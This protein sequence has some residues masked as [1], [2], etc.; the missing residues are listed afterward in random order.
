MKILVVIFGALALTSVVQGRPVCEECDEIP[1]VVVGEDRQK[2]NIIDAPVVCPPGQK[3]DHKGK[4]RDVW[5]KIMPVEWFEE[6]SVAKP[7]NIIDAPV[8]CPPGQ[9]P[10]HKGK[11]RDVWTRRAPQVEFE[12][13]SDVDQSN[14]IDGPV[15]CPPGQK[16]DHNGKCRDVWSKV[17]PASH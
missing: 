13:E 4:C 3:P 6:E 2:Q 15:V 8:V 7:K 12:E 5:T 17:A 9:K 14:I 16:P 1:V 10:D 11:C